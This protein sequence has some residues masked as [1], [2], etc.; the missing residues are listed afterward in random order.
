MTPLSIA[1][2]V[3][4]GGDD[5]VTYLAG[6][7]V[8][9]LF[10]S[11]A[12]KGRSL[13]RLTVSQVVPPF[14]FAADSPGLLVSC[15]VLWISLPG[16]KRRVTSMKA[17]EGLFLVLLFEHSFDFTPPPLWAS[18]PSTLAVFFWPLLLPPSPSPPLST[19]D[20]R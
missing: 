7:A 10:V 4:G 16:A 9:D 12:C 6:W 11:A 17:R 8:S 14:V 1:L 15:C 20:L 5:C 3:V 13:C 2:F 19:N 18:A